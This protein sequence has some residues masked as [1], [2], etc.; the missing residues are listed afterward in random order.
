MSTTGM[1]SWGPHEHAPHKKGVRKTNERVRVE[2]VVLAEAREKE[3][4]LRGKA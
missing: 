2:V 1:K 4:L 3:R